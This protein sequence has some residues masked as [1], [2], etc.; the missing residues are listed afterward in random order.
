[1][2]MS[3]Q[4]RLSSDGE[5]LRP[6]APLYSD[7]TVAFYEEGTHTKPHRHAEAHRR[8]HLLTICI[9]SV[10]LCKFPEQ[11]KPF[12][13]RPRGRRMYCLTT[14]SLSQ[15]KRDLSYLALSH[16]CNQWLSVCWNCCLSVATATTAA[17]SSRLCWPHSPLVSRGSKD[18][19]KN[20]F[21][22]PL[23]NGLPIFQIQMNSF[24]W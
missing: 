23:E 1:M 22:F 21:A 4:L 9:P 24:G 14:D 10:Y 16:H 20:G 19:L 11:E 5:E 15:N 18:F 3:R 8:H 13:C 12:S 2:L 7:D 6:P 17:F